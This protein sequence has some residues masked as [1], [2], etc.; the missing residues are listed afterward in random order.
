MRDLRS[1]CRMQIILVII[2]PII[3]MLIN[4]V[5]DTI[6]IFWNKIDMRARPYPPSFRRIAAKTIDPAIGASTCALGSHK[7]VE[8]IGSFTKKPIK[9]INQNIDLIEK[10]WGKVNSD[11]IDI[12]RWFEYKY[13]EQNMINIGSEAVIVYNIRY[14]LAWRRSGWYPHVIIIA[15]VGISE[16][17]NQI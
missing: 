13:I 3:E 7:W 17:S 12:N 4:I 10:K 9:V 6:T 1:G 8:N 14:K 11:D 16:A 15:I 2:A 5:E